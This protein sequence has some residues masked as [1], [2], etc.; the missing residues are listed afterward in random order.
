V[1]E[2]LWKIEINGEEFFCGI[3]G[4]LMYEEIIKEWERLNNSDSSDDG[5]DEA[6]EVTG[7]S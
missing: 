2:G 3:E 6:E 7:L 1:E 4:K 5:Q